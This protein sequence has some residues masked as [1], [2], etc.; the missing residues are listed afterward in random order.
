M[1]PLS[2]LVF[3]GRAK[4]FKGE[5]EIE[6]QGAAMGEESVE[7]YLQVEFIPMKGLAFGGRGAMRTF[8]NEDADGVTP[9][10][11]WLW[12]ASVEYSF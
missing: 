1:K 11:E 10:D 8:F 12:R 2:W 5:L 9:P 6:E 4:Y 3:S 7:A